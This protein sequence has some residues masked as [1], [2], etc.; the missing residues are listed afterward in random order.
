VD[1]DL[2]ALVVASL[3][4]RL[5]RFVGCCLWYKVCQQS[6]GDVGMLCIGGGDIA[7]AVIPQL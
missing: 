4:Q 3:L 6:I 1:E 2:E 5:K 7:T